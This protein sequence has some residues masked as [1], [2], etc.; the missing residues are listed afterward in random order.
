[1]LAS[2][3][4]TL[5]EGRARFII[6]RQKL[7]VANVSNPLSVTRCLTSSPPCIVRIRVDDFFSEWKGRINES[8][9]RSDV[10]MHHYP[11]ALF[12][13]HYLT[14]GTYVFYLPKQNVF[15]FWGDCSMDHAD[16]VSGPFAGDPRVVLKK[17]AEDE[18]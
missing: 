16:E 13:W 14:T 3:E 2:A 6:K 4:K 8:T 15:Y 5:V 9:L 10:F 18:S 7:E 1:S 11:H 17:L 12:D